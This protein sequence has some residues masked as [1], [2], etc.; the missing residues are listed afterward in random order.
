MKNRTITT[1]LVAAAALLALADAASAYYSPRLGRFLNRDPIA[2][3][4]AALVRAAGKQGTQFVSRDPVDKN[5][6]VG[7]RNNA[8]NW[9]DP[10]GTDIYLKTGNDSGNPINDAIHQNV[11]VDTWHN[12]RRGELACFSFGATSLWPRFSSVRR[13]WL[14]WKLPIWQ[15]TGL[16]TMEGEIYEADDTGVWVKVK[17]ATPEQDQKWLNWMRAKRVGIK[18]IYTAAWFNCRN[19]AQREYDDAP[20]DH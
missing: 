16:C 19:Y 1:M 8:V 7:M 11:C 20:G 18:D 17:G 2:E 12:G 4:G 6:Y 10:H 14:G 13:T 9:I 15:T 3:P 5:E